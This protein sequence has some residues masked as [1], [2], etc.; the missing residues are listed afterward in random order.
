MWKETFFC[1]IKK[2]LL[3]PQQK[4]T[5][6][7]KSVFIQFKVQFLQLIFLKGV[8]IEFLCFDFITKMIC[9]EC[10]RWL[11]LSK[12]VERGFFVKNLLTMICV[13]FSF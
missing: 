9:I 1:G 2:N 11:H 6:Q 10:G 4:N 3:S 5:E 7:S 8:N 13:L 12:W